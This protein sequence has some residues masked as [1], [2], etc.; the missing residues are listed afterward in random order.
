MMNAEVSENGFDFYTSDAISRN[1]HCDRQSRIERG[2]QSRRADEDPPDSSDENRGLLLDIIS[3]MRHETCCRPTC[4][5]N[6]AACQVGC[7]KAIKRILFG[8]RAGVDPSP[9]DVSL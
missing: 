9:V 6:L 2:H 1:F 7:K 5:A 4:L 3:V 8:G